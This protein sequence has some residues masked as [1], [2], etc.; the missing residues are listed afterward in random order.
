MSRMKRG[1]KCDFR[2]WRKFKQKRL[3]SSN[4]KYSVYMDLEDKYKTN[5]A[6]SFN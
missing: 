4:V 2:C 6:E 3:L 1:I 5:T